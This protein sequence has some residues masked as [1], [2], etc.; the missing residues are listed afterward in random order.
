[1]LFSGKFSGNN[2]RARVEKIQIIEK[3]LLE[4]SKIPRTDSNLHDFI[5]YVRSDIWHAKH[6]L[7]ALDFMSGSF[8]VPRAMSDCNTSTFNPNEGNG[9][10][11]NNLARA[12]EEIHRISSTT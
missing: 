9:V 10:T 2:S 12:E 11:A 1:M 8:H 6:I 4:L 5:Y 3:M 7:F